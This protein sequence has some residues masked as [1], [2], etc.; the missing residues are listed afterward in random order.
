[1][2]KKKALVRGLASN[3]ECDFVAVQEQSNA[4]Q[5]KANTQMVGGIQRLGYKM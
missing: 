1:M 2:W 5:E 4:L 3:N